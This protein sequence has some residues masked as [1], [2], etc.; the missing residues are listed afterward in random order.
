MLP[1]I[2][3]TGVT[4]RNS[5]FMDSSTMDCCTQ[6]LLFVTQRIPLEGFDQQLL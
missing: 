4:A 6:A 2:V 3:L 1:H 5:K